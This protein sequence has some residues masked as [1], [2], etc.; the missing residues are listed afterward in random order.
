MEE[1]ELAERCRHGDAIARKELYE[2]YGG[3]ML[4][5][6][7]RYVGDYETAQDLLHDGFL[8]LFTSFDKFEWRGEGSIRA[9]IERVMINTALQ[10]LRRN[11]LINFT[12]QIEAL[13]D[14]YAAP[15]EST[16]ERIP[17]DMLMK[18]IG[19]LPDGYRTVLNLHVFEE[20]SH[21]EIAQLLGINENSSTSQMARAK[22]LLAK[23]IHEWEKRN[24]EREERYVSRK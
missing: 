17:N 18:F 16:I 21:K 5:L 3:Q 8:K 6:C 4:A 24:K 23:K 9:W 10:Y 14:T 19:E 13:S 7:R 15:H 2:R 1:Q 12:D 11:K 22:A 20:K